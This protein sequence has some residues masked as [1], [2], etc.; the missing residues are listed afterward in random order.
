MNYKKGK[1]LILIPKININGKKIE[2]SFIKKGKGKPQKEK[3]DLKLPKNL[4]I[5]LKNY[6]QIFKKN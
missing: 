2:L 1:N 4:N 3:I 5:K 6:S